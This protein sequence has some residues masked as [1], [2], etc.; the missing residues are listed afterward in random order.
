MRPFPPRPPRSID[1]MDN[2]RREDF[3]HM[4]LFINHVRELVLT[5]L[6]LSYTVAKRSQLRPPV[7][8][9]LN[10]SNNAAVTYR[11]TVE[12]RKIWSYTVPNQAS[13]ECQWTEQLTMDSCR[14]PLRACRLPSCCGTLNL[15]CKLRTRRPSNV[16][17]NLPTTQTPSSSGRFN[18]LLETI[19]HRL[20]DY[21][22]HHHQGS[23]TSNK[24]YPKPGYK[25]IP[26]DTSH[27]W[28]P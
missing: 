1:P 2:H 15:V 21:R 4:Y 28:N 9:S 3:S 5:P 26:T 14:L 8:R 10:I 16:C 7:Y 20:K 27:T 13:N 17:A 12:S 6:L 18:R 19:L 25:P 23:S 11:G 24:S 22:K